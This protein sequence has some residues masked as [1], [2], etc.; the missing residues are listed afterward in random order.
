MTEGSTT[1]GPY[2]GANRSPND[3]ELLPG[4]RPAGDRVG[5][6]PESPAAQHGGLADQPGGVADLPDQGLPVD[7][8]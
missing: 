7:P 2:E 8:A 4:E 3:D 1:G 5:P 6:A